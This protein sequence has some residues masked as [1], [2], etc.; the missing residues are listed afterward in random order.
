MDNTTTL[1]AINMVG[2]YVGQAFNFTTDGQSTPGTDIFLSCYLAGTR[3]LTVHG[4]VPVESLREGDLVVTR[5]GSDTRCGPVRWIGVSRIDL[6][7]HPK[8]RTVTPIRILAGA[9]GDGL[10]HRDLLLSPDHAVY[11]EGV[12]IPIQYL[13]N[14][15]TIRREAIGG[16]V[17]YYHVELDA[18]DVLVADGLQVESYLDT[19]D[20]ANFENG[21][22]VRA[23]YPNFVTSQWESAGCAPLVVTGPVLQAVRD[24]VNA[25][26]TAG[27]ANSTAKVSMLQANGEHDKPYPSKRLVMSSAG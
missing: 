6:D 17:T 16:V 7:R 1:A 2:N 20:R 14:D 13:V 10:P 26:V 12:L 22:A 19:G 18:H 4:E 8:P 15:A 25:L 21:G 11:V 27:V 5:L 9:F 3:I 23:L 24:R